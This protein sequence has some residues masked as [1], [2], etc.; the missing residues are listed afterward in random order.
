MT[1]PLRSAPPL[2]SRAGGAKKRPTRYAE[3][4]PPSDALTRAL[5]LHRKSRLEEAEVAY[6]EAIDD[7][8]DSLDAW[9]N[10]GASLVLLGR[11][12]EAAAAYER[13]LRIG[14]GVARAQRDAAIGLTAVG[15]FPRAR[16]AFEAALRLD[17]DRVGA[18]L[19]LSRLLAEMGEREGA[20]HHAEEAVRSAPLDPSSHLELHRARFDADALDPAIGAARRAVE[21]WPDY[22]LARLFLSG[23]LAWQGRADEAA[24]VLAANAE[25]H[26]SAARID[27]GFLDALDYCARHRGAARTFANKRD[28]LLHALDEARLSGPILELGVRQGVSTRVLASATDARLHAFDSFCGLPDAWHTKGAGSFTTA[29]QVPSVDGDVV[30]HV[31]LFSDTLPAYTAT[32]IEIPRLVHIDS[33]LYESAATALTSLG[34]RLMPGVVLVFDEYLGNAHWRAD[35]YRAFQEAVE[36]WGL[37]YEYLALSWITGQASVR[38][39]T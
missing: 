31:G 1:E 13:A 25:T 2:R 16:A 4:A 6:R 19:G 11:A 14:S 8:A 20:I 23:A 28:T 22:A 15:L 29:G 18:R 3:A 10:L 12:Q 26:G 38:I 17:P 37:R 36:T 5:R 30:F 9:M 7:D 33:D 39:T 21:L 27:P 24:R 35:E 34:P 32:S